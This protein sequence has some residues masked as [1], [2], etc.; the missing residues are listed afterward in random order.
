[1]KALKD[2]LKRWLKPTRLFQHY[3]SYRPKRWI[4]CSIIW[5]R[6]CQKVPIT[7]NFW[8]MCSGHSSVISD[9]CTCATFILLFLRSWSTTPNTSSP[10]RR[11]SVR[12]IK[13]VLL[14]L[15]MDWRWAWHI[16]SQFW[17]NGRTLTHYSGQH[18][19]KNFS[20]SR[21]KLLRFCL[22]VKM[23]KNYSKRET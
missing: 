5:R 2:C 12:R 9:T 11:S 4:K 6:T 18:P 15:M 20:S 21:S 22:T 13:K 8:L 10:V 1:M 3:R 23:L 19:F 17:I 7:S 14:S 16:V